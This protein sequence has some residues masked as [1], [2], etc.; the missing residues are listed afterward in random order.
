MQCYFRS[1]VDGALVL[2]SHE[3]LPDTDLTARSA[4]HLV[5]CIAGKITAFLS[6]PDMTDAGVRPQPSTGNCQRSP[7]EGTVKV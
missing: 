5:W 6:S 1:A 3:S 4:W 2:A 7:R